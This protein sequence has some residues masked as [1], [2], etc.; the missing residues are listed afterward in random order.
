LLTCHVANSAGLLGEG[1]PY[2]RGD[3]DLDALIAGLAPRVEY[4]VTET[5][6]IDHDRAVEMRRALERMRRCL[7][8][9]VGR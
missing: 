1:E 6:E 4:F 9:A 2:D 5:L 3:L 8:A 7:G